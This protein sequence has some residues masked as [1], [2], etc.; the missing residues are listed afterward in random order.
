MWSQG[1]GSDGSVDPRRVF[2][3]F[4][5]VVKKPCLHG[6]LI[7]SRLRLH[8]S[9]P[10]GVLVERKTAVSRYSSL[11]RGARNAGSECSVCVCVCVFVPLIISSVCTCSALHISVALHIWVIMVHTFRQVS[12]GHTGGGKTQGLF[13]V[14]MLLFLPHLPLAVLPFIFI[15]RRVQPSV[16][17]V[18]N[19]FDVCAYVLSHGLITGLSL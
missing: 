15:A 17:V 2:V 12:R 14:F 4:A 16:S 5:H 7:C 6:L 19:D 11:A 1:Q 8:I 10:I 18:N 3:F 13:I 9:R